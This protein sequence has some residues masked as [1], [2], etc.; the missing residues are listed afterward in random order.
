[1]KPPRDHRFV[2]VNRDNFDT[3]FGMSARIRGREGGGLMS[4]L[5]IHRTSTAD[6]DLIAGPAEISLRDHRQ[7]ELLNRWIADYVT[8]ETAV[9][10][11]DARRPLSAAR[12][13]VIEPSDTSPGKAVCFLMHRGLPFDSASLRVEVELP[14]PRL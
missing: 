5:L 12:I 7:L 9:F 14:P 4:G 10:G 2:E 3:V 11:P 1:M 13:S 8:P 6:G